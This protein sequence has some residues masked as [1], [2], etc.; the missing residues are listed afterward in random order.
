MSNN[1]FVLQYG[2]IVKKLPGLSEEESTGMAAQFAEGV[3]MGFEQ[4]VEIWKNKRPSTTRCCRR[5]TVR[6]TSCVAGT[7]SST[8][9]SKTS[10][11]T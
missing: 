4:D 11:K 9:M 3:E 1:E 8:S 7:S 5:R 10:R 6:S 2:A